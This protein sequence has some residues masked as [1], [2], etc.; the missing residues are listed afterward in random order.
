MSYNCCSTISEF[1]T[2]EN[3]KC[4]QNSWH[5]F[6]SFTLKVL[7]ARL[8][9]MGKLSQ[10]ILGTL[11]APSLTSSVV[12]Q[13][14]NFFLNRKWNSGI[15]LDCYLVCTGFSCLERVNPHSSFLS[16]AGTTHP[17]IESYKIQNYKKWC[18]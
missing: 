4:S 17:L 11:E 2:C 14:L 8:Y 6:R 12:N 13:N 9:M 10:G 16:L 18:P 7:G 15:I 5:S 3:K 1:N